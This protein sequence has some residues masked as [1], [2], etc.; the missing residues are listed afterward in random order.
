MPT[1][2]ISNFHLTKISHPVIPDLNKL[3]LNKEVKTKL[4]NQQL[5]LNKFAGSIKKKQIDLSGS[6]IPTRLFTLRHAY[7]EPSNIH[8]KNISGALAL[9][10]SISEPNN[11]NRSY[12]TP[13]QKGGLARSQPNYQP[14]QALRGPQYIQ[15][16]KDDKIAAYQSLP[17][18]V[19]NFL[20]EKLS[21]KILV[22]FKKGLVG[23]EV[24]KYMVAYEEFKQGV[25]DKE[26]EQYLQ[27]KLSGLMPDNRFQST[28]TVWIEL[29]KLKPIQT[30]EEITKVM[31]NTKCSH[32]NH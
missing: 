8:K 4:V 18:V 6:K 19:K 12:R 32:L 22:T 16:A 29:D 15:K 10:R 3:P 20:N 24:K 7:S 21:Y 27:I 5:K 23:K 9:N 26:K 13:V 28:K 11:L 2:L 31:V 1:Q 17:D 30:K 25:S 14:N